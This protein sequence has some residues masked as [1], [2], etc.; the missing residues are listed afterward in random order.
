MLSNCTSRLML[1]LMLT[2]RRDAEEKRLREKPTEGK[3]ERQ[4]R[5]RQSG[6]TGLRDRSVDQ[7]QGDSSQSSRDEELCRRTQLRPGSA[8]SP[9]G[10]GVRGQGSVHR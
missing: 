6:H 4:K 10:S 5:R 7:A 9:G 2:E 1:M 8:V 3:V